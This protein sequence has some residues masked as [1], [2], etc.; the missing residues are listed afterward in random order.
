MESN[1]S[2]VKLDS[3]WKELFDRSHKSEKYAKSDE[4]AS[5]MYTRMALEL[6]VDF[7]Y[8]YEGLGNQNDKLFN[9]TESRSFT[10]LYNT[11]HSLDRNDDLLS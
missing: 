5:F 1:F 9:K 7:I 6:I 3:D 2:C 4:R 10:S 11:P 8:E